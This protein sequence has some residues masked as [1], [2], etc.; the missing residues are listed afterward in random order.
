MGGVASGTVPSGTATFYFGAKVLGT[1]SLRPN[2]ASCAS[3]SAVLSVSSLPLGT[4]SVTAT[5]NGDADYNPVTSS[6]VNVVVEEPSNLS[7]SVNPS[8]VNLYF[9]NGG[10]TFFRA[11]SPNLLG[12]W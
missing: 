12:F 11:A 2:S 4:D 7:A 5:Y 1:A 9:S 8:S 6:P 10:R 3:S